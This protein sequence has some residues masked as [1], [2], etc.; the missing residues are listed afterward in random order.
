MSFSL[1]LFETVGGLVNVLRLAPGIQKELV[2]RYYDHYDYYDVNHCCCYR[3]INHFRRIAAISVFFFRTT[4]YGTQWSFTRVF[5]VVCL[6][7]N[8]CA[9]KFL[10]YLPSV[11]TSAPGSPAVVIPHSSLS[12]HPSSRADPV[13]LLPCTLNSL[14]SA[15][16]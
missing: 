6:L 11:A 9:V 16:G 13:D 14:S 12:E 4:L 2:C 15:L 10:L 1:F 8:C 7:T 5:L 3:L